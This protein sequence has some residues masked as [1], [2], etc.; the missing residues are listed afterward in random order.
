MNED[1]EALLDLLIC[2]REIQRVLLRLASSVDTKDFDA[3]AELYAEDGELVTPW[4]AN[5]GRDGLAAHARSDLGQFAALHHVSAGHEIDVE[6]GAE[7]ASAR[8]T[9]L[10]THVLDEDGKIFS[11]VGGHY[12]IK[13]VREDDRWRL[14]RVEIKPAWHLDSRD[15]IEDGGSSDG[16]REATVFDSQA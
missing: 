7:T 11:T 3:L 14:L 13:L 6:P 10:A 15:F 12:D 9:L 1:R 8:M 5:R 4:G 16:V 2:E